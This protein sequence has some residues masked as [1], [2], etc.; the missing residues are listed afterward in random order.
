MKRPA[1]ILA[2]L[3]APLAA[4]A[5]NE[6]VGTPLAAPADIASVL[7]RPV[8]P[9]PQAEASAQDQALFTAAKAGDSARCH[10]LIK[11]GANPNAIHKELSLLDWAIKGGNKR[12]VTTLLEV[13]ADPNFLGPMR[14]TPMH[15]GAIVHDPW[16]LETLLAHGGDPNVRNVLGETPLFRAI[17]W[18]ETSK[19]IDLLLKAGADIH[20]KA[21]DGRTLLHQAALVH[22]HDDLWRFLQMGVD[23]RARD[24]LGNTFQR[25][26]FPYPHKEAFGKKVRAWLEKNGIPVESEADWK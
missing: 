8:N 21:K 16:Y 3:A 22:A 23:P 19:N 18:G 15:L 26:F 2:L 7:A 12:A 13:G 4:T 11:Q 20:A 9:T 5:D 24:D 25:D 1:L 10:E 17:G 14:D 6:A